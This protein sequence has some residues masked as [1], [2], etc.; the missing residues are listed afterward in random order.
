MESLPPGP[1]L[2]RA[3]Q[4]LLWMFRP[5]QL[6]EHCRRKYGDTFTLRLSGFPPAVLFSNPNEVR[7][8]FTGDPEI[9][10]GGAGNQNLKPL[11]GDH[12]VLLLDGPR[13][14]RQRKLLLPPFHG[15][16]M[17]SYAGT[18][19]Q[20]TRAAIR[21]WPFERAFALHPEM[22]DI[23]LET[24]LRTV[25]GIADADELG[26]L[27]GLLK[28]VLS[29][30]EHPSLLLLIR[31]D[32]SVRLRG[33]QERLG[34]LSPWMRFRRRLE[35]IDALLF[36]QIEARRRAAGGDDILSLLL[37]A[38]DEAGAPLSDR[39]LR[40]E[41][42][43]LLVAGHET[44]AA[45][46]TW[47]IHDVLANPGVERALRG[48]AGADRDACLDAI[49]RETQR[50]H[51]VFNVVGRQLAKSMTIGGRSY[52]AGVVVT[53]VAWLAQR[54]PRWWPDAT[55]FRPE[56]FL[57]DKP[58]AHQY[59]P[60]GGGSRRCIGMSFALHQMRVVLDEVLATS[61]LSLLPG[62]VGRPVRRGLTFTLPGGLPVVRRQISDG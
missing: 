32:G 57:D 25:F 12:S 54:D 1:P 16:R 59:F 37:G 48:R 60:F 19:R 23:A 44:T 11:L 18:I 20:I 15:E 56:R 10:L 52:P 41:I 61:S 26:R 7:E 33:L 6:L 13:H 14:L 22:Q 51:P 28:S 8:I 2:P 43:T 46:L 27:G 40:D 29:I 34:R 24:I 49:I 3:V 58:G 42:M 5:T 17:R 45:A 53:P 62:Y 55:R 47:T 39:E 21:R 30:G 36:A 35:E 31:A 4:T 38:R 50:L 9:L